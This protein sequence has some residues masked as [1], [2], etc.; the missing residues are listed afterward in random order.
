[1]RN[2][3]HRLAVTFLVAVAISFAQGPAQ[4]P[5]DHLPGEQHFHAAGIALRLV[6]P[7]SILMTVGARSEDLQNTVRVF[8]YGDDDTTSF[9]LLER[10]LEVYFQDRIPVV[11]DGKRLF[12]RVTQWKP[13]GQGRADGLDMPSLYVDNLF[14][15]MGARLP[16][17][18]KAVD[19]TANLWLER[20]DA[21]ETV[22]QF[23]LFEG[24]QPL[25]RL[26]THREQ[27]VRFPLTPDSL[28]AMR[29]NPPAP[30]QVAPEELGDP[31]ERSGHGHHDHDGHDH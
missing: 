8:P 17:G 3:F 15:T 29:A 11:V 1:M 16:K 2:T 24:S 10:R 5:H 18:A 21:A 25:R 31:G 9:R 6:A 23:S 20:E 28:A 12:F 7:D 19:V 14:I 26:W 22:V 27:T 30:L 4:D 13:R